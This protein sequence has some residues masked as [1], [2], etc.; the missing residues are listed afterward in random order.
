[1]NDQ[2]ITTKEA[3]KLFEEITGESRAQTAIQRWARRGYIQSRVLTKTMILVDRE[4]L[5]RYAEQYKAEK[6]KAR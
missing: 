1:M 6:V 5:I 4:S 2:E 3:I